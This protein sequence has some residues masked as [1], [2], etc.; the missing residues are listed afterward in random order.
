MII[1]QDAGIMPGAAY[2]LTMVKKILVTGG[3]GYIGSVVVKELLDRGYEVKVLDKLFFGK[4]CLA[5]VEPKIEIIQ[6]DIRKFDPKI[7]SDVD[8]I[9]HLAALSN[10][11]TAEYNPK[12]NFDINT[13]GTEIVAEA[14]KKK[15]IERFVYASSCSVYYSPYP[16]EEMMS[17]KSKINPSAPYSKS[18]YLA[19]QKLLEM[20]GKDFKPTILRKG[21]VFG[22]SPRM[23]YDLVV[24]TFVKDAYQK[25]KLSINS[26][27]EMYR[28]LVSINDVAKAYVAC[29]EAPVD[30]VDGQIFNLVHKN[31]IILALAHWTKYVL[32]DKKNIEIDVDYGKDPPRSYRVDGSKIK[33]AIGFE[34]KEGVSSAINEMWTHLEKNANTINDPVHYNI[35]W[36]ELLEEMQGRLKNMDGVFECE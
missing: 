29:L 14:A 34:A 4:K 19:E 32:R 26:G 30:K 13:R 6:G 33:D 27:G 25:G 1:R 7:L 12:A 20:R 10:D 22:Y 36:M 3:A 28:P 5:E 24:N 23:R 9:F 11:P 31:Y 35:R 18:K 15:G 2:R 17:E 8:G 21:T 16:T